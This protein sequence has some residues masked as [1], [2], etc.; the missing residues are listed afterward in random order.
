MNT[1]A[2]FV[3][4]YLVVDVFCIIM[5]TVIM[6]KVDQGFGSELEIH[7]FKRMIGSYLLF[8]LTDA[9]WMPINCALFGVDPIAN[10]ILS[11]INMIAMSFVGYFWFCYGAI[12]RAP[13]CLVACGTASTEK[14]SS[15]LP[16]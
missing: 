15:P 11:C 9:L 5:A 16:R 4:S 7:Y 12:G 6:R 14:V 2:L 13:R 10:V 8:C 3:V 1:V